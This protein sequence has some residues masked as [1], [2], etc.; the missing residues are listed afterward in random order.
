VID[1]AA[2]MLPRPLSIVALVVTHDGV[3]GVS[4]G[5]PQSA[6][7]EAARLSSRTHVRWLERPLQRVLSVMPLMYDDLWVAAKGAYKMEPAMADG[8]EIII[9]APHVRAVSHV[10]GKLIEEIGYH[11]RDYFVKQWDRF[12]QYPGGILAH[13]THVKGI[14][15]Y[16]AAT[17]IESPRITVTLSTGIGPD[18]CRRINLG[19]LDPASVD[20]DAWP[21]EVQQGRLKVPRAGEL[22]YRIGSPPSRS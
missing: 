22:L 13:S 17:G 21:V 9:Y 4:V 7:R 5:A 20:L 18:V 6:W 10:H 15:T 1:R 14:G 3:V 12:R 11:C 2:S 8:G 16:D 19:Y